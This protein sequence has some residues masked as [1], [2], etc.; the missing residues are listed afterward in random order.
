MYDRQGGKALFQ[1]E[2]D[3]Y[4]TYVTQVDDYIITE[5][6]TADGQRYGLLLIRYRSVKNSSVKLLSGGSPCV[7]EISV[8]S[9]AEYLR[10]VPSSV[11]ATVLIPVIF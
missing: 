5:Y 6:I 2:Q 11:R 9:S 10:S 4:L 1:L 3:A 8:P 7:V